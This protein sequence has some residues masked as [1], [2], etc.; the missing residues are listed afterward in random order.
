[1]QKIILIV[2]DDFQIREALRKIL[3][4]EGYHVVLAADGQEGVEK[5]RTQPIDLVLLDL[6]LPV[7]SGWDAFERLTSANP[8]LPVFIITG[9]QNQY[10]L[11]AAAG[12]GALMEKPLDVPFLLQTIKELLAEPP[13]VRLQ[14]LAGWHSYVRYIHPPHS[15][16]ANQART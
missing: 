12:A 8:L 5:S 7:Q 4:T 2:E 16:A 6:N 14:R 9:R 1:M 11:A 3:Q 15:L 10:E 13:E